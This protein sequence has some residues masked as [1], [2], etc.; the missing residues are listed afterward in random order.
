[1]TS[2]AAGVVVD[3]PVAQWHAEVIARV[4]DGQRFAGVY[5]TH[6]GDTAQLH[7]LQWARRGR[8]ACAPA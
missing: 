2:T 1:M 6:R 8:I 4:A 5:C 3:L 7:A